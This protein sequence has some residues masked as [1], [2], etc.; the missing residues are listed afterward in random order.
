MNYD[1][2][3][4]MSQAIHTPH[5]SVKNYNGSPHSSSSTVHIVLVVLT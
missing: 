1:D 4:D 2:N 5:N 3:N